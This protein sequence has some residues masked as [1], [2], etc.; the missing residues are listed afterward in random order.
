MEYEV[1][2]ELYRKKWNHIATYTFFSFKFSFT[3]VALKEKIWPQK[4]AEVILILKTI[5]AN[6]RLQ[7]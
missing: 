7:P 2:R 1:G 5:T 6:H 3:K 4:K